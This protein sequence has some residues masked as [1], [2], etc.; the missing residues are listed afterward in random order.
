MDFQKKVCCN[1]FPLNFDSQIHDVNSRAR[2]CEGP[3]EVTLADGFLEI[4]KVPSVD[5]RISVVLLYC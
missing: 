5:D 4:V 3:A 1:P 2:I